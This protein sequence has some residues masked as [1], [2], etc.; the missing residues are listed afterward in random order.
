MYILR[1]TTNPE[2]LSFLLSITRENCQPM[3]IQWITDYPL[4]LEIE[5]EWNTLVRDSSL[6][7]LF[8]THQW[9]STWWNAFHNSME[10][11]ILLVRENGQL[12]GIAPLLLD[13][14]KIRIFPIRVLRFIS[15]GISPR[16]MFITRKGHEGAV[17]A[18]CS[19]LVEKSSEWDML[20]LT[21]VPEYVHGYSSL[22]KTLEKQHMHFY[23]TNSRA[24]PYLKITTQNYETYMNT[25]SANTRSYIKRARNK[26]AKSGEVRV[27]K[28]TDCK[29][30]LANLKNAFGI[31]A[32][33]WKEPIGTAMGATEQSRQFYRQISD[34]GGKNGWIVLWILFL[35]DQAISMQYH[36]QYNDTIYL[37]RTD[38]DEHYRKT[39]P[40][41]VLES[42]VL[43][44]Y[45][46]NGVKEYDFCGMDYDYKM[47]W[48]EMTHDHKTFHIFN[49]S[50]YSS[51]L[52]HLKQ[53]FL[54]F[55]R[56]IKG[57]LAN[58]SRPSINSLI[59]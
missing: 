37:A 23:I 56:K 6:D 20:L 19:A 59:L 9:F 42:F 51:T 11:R 18:I 22:I 54:P 27:E 41:S 29:K 4:F 48:T 57:I 16:C 31:S 46:S 40:G 58:N 2:K 24:S 32:K 26:L 30:I 53:D 15:N 10:M 14:I 45:I 43:E 44:D 38:F 3:N 52:F 39:S 17:E 35:N 47:K 34:I 8:L 49:R 25:R 55:V 12:V 33:S 28:I 21:D 1:K 36:F 13:R 5:D 50:M 7:T